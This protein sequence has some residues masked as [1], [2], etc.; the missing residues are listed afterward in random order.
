MSF[1]LLLHYYISFLNLFEKPYLDFFEENPEARDI[2][3][4]LMCLLYMQLTLVQISGTTCGSLS[5][6]GCGNRK[7]IEDEKEEE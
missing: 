1:W 5:T 7:K 2:V 4:N 6:V 3:H